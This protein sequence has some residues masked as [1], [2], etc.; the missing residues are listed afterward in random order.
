MCSQV[1]ADGKADF[2]A[3]PQCVA[4]KEVVAGGMYTQ[5]V[6][7]TNISEAPAAFKVHADG[8]LC[9]DCMLVICKC[10]AGNASVRLELTAQQRQLPSVSDGHEVR[11]FLNGTQ[12]EDMLPTPSVPKCLCADLAT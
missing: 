10:C 5:A 1:N 4:F 2:K 11:T 6:V 7:L 3:S 8:Y 12:S 9:Q